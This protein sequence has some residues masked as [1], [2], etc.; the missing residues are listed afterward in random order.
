MELVLGIS[1]MLHPV[2]RHPSPDTA[3]FALSRDLFGSDYY[4]DFT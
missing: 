2:P 1:G 4:L 3:A